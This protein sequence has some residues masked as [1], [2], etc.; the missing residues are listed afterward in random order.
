MSGGSEG[1]SVS[2]SVLNRGAGTKPSPLVHCIVNSHGC[3]GPDE[4]PSTSVK[5]VLLPSHKG[6]SSMSSNLKM[7]LPTRLAASEVLTCA[8]Q[9]NRVESKTSPLPIQSFFCHDHFMVM[10][11]PWTLPAL[12]SEATVP[13]QERQCYTSFTTRIPGFTF[14]CTHGLTFVVGT[15]FTTR[16]LTFVVGTPVTP[17][18]HGHERRILQIQNEVVKIVE[19]FIQNTAST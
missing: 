13:S 6:G 11:S 7:S 2:K 16:G 4:F 12:S 8:N 9:L 14:C 17:V 19:S 5:I 18:R 15:P 1:V 10:T 3:P